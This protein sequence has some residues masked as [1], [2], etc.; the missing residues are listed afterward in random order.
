MK[1]SNRASCDK[2][3]KFGEN[4]QFGMCNKIGYRPLLKNS[5]CAIFRLEYLR[6]VH[7]TCYHGNFLTASFTAMK[8]VNPH[9]LHAEKLGSGL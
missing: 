2:S 5:P 9:N 6:L 3:M 1:G 4:T 7:E 8:F